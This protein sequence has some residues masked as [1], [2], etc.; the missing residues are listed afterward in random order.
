MDIV[1]LIGRVLFALIFIGS[2]IGHLAKQADSV[3]YAK[4]SNAPAP[5][6]MVPLTGVMLLLGGLS[7]AFGVWADVGALLILAFLIPTAFIMHAFWKET[8]PQAAQG[9]RAHF[10]KNIAL[11]GGALIIF[12]F[13]NQ[14]QGGAP[15]S[16]TDPLFGRW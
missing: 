2:G 7:V 14:V 3:A 6:L 4:A 13:Y 15:L 16:F 5:E 1:F 12:Y 9:Q 10:M 8:D 11:A